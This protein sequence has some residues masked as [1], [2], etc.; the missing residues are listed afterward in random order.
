MSTKMKLNEEEMKLDP[1][2]VDSYSP[3][4]ETPI[5][6]NRINKNALNHDSARFYL[7]CLEN[8]CY[9]CVRIKKI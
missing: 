3:E 9:L 6:Y 1:Q 8:Y 2:V 4:V 7:H 5:W